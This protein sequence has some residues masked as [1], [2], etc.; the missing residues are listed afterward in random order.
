MPTGDDKQRRHR[1]FLDRDT[2]MVH[3][4]RRRPDG[5]EVVPALVRDESHS[6]LA[7]VIVGPA[8]AG[9][10]EFLH[11][12]NEKVL[13]PLALRRHEELTRDVHLLGLE[14]VERA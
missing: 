13:T 11:R 5:E 10:E 6:G 7:C 1:R 3:L 2:R 14:R 4:I 9:D 12:E 8:P